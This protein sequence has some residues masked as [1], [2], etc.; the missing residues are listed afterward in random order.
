MKAL[1]LA[2]GFATRLRPLS[3]SRPKTLFPVVN[4]PLLQWIFERLAK[5]HIEEAILAVNGLTAF[6]VKQQRV[7]K[8]GLN[9]KYS[10][11]P[12]KTPL[13]T[14][15][16]VKNAEKLIGHSEPFMVL[17]GDIFADLSYTEI[18]EKHKE[19][20]NLAT[21]ALCQA[22]DPSRYGVA[23]LAANSRITR[24]I[25]KPAKGTAPTNLIN[26]GIYVLSPKIFQ[27]I[28]KGKMVSMEREVFPKLV[29][30]GEL[31]GH[32]FQGLWMD[33][34]KPEEYLQ[35]NKILLD[36]LA[37]IPKPK[38][39]G[40]FKLNSPVALGKSVHIGAKSVI[41]PYAILGKNVT[42]G[43]NV[44]ISESVILSDV[45]INDSSSINGA[46]I[47]E[48]ATI[49]KK[50]RIGKGCVIGDQAKVRDNIS[51]TKQVAV[52]PAKEVSENILKSKIIC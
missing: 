45:K 37:K 19:R 35:T 3:C 22:E 34:G 4:K 49:G 2:G 36:S 32:V 7:P 14:G 47:G 1:I 20:G 48:G 10:I 51:L 39:A 15:G 13:G 25:E 18:L 16:P 41:G 24:F 11:D 43:K 30:E 26:A 28:P 44:Q 38:N 5:N 8:Y 40:K 33:I 42:V 31:Y 17:N 6:Y 9:V 50:V 29:E 12:P 27:Y 52:C 21:I 46:I 23:E